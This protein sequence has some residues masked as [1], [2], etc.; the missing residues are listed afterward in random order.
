MASV[1]MCSQGQ[2]AGGRLTCCDLQQLQHL[3]LYASK[4]VTDEAV[5]CLAQL[6]A[7][8]ALDLSKAWRL[9]GST[10]G[11]VAAVTSLV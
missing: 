3:D 2:G 4:D 8:T 6:K 1:G 9:Q 7:F 10:L 5:A 11:Q